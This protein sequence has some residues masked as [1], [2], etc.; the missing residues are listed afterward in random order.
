ML[1]AIGKVQGV[2]DGNGVTIANSEPTLRF[3]QDDE[4]VGE[5][6]LKS[7]TAT[8]QLQGL[9]IGLTVTGIVIPLG[10]LVSGV[11]Y[12]GILW[13]PWE[14]GVLSQFD[15][16]KNRAVS[17][18]A[19]RDVLLVVSDKGKA[20]LF[21]YKGPEFTDEPFSK[22]FEVDFGDIGRVQNATLAIL[23]NED[24]VAASFKEKVVVKKIRHL[25]L[26]CLKTADV[27]AEWL[28]DLVEASADFKVCNL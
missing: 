8:V 9:V 15:G 18:D 23:G 20:F 4:L 2:V 25:P 28:T 22:P 21:K 19:I 5:V 14:K 13:K 16:T 3:V 1:L 6:D 27:E 17:I 26:S 12:E 10:Q 7:L 24:V 11:S